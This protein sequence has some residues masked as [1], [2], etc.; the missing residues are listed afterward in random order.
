MVRYHHHIEA[1]KNRLL[2]LAIEQETEGRVETLFRTMLA[3]SQSF[4]R[5][6]GHR[7]VVAGLASPVAHDHLEIRGISLGNAQDLNHSEH[8]RHNSRDCDAR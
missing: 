7:D 8:F 1:S 4:P 3:A 6:L 2:R 5:R